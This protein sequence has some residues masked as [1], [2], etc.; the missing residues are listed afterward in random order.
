[1]TH[2]LRVQPG[3][4]LDTLPVSKTTVCWLITSNNFQT[5]LLVFLLW[6][7]P[8]NFKYDQFWTEKAV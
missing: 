3:L 5:S 7:F 4:E 1:M 2:D 8:A 6:Q